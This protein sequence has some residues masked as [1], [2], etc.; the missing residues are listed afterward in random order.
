MESGLSL[1][2]LACSPMAAHCSCSL[3]SDEDWG[4]ESGGTQGPGSLG[5]GTMSANEVPWGPLQMGGG[6]PGP[7]RGQLR[8]KTACCRRSE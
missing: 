4:E 1:Q 8:G 7:P 2:T 6:H 5:G 3:A